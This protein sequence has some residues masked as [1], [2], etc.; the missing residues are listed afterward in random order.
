VID[1]EKDF[2]NLKD[3]NPVLIYLKS[4]SKLQSAAQSSKTIYPHQGGVLT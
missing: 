1:N 3:R 4:M 2:V